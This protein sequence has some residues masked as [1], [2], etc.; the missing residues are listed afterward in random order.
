MNSFFSVIGIFCIMCVSHYLPN[1]SNYL[2]SV[3]I[4]NPT[5]L[6]E[7]LPTQL[8]LFVTYLKMLKCPGLVYLFDWKQW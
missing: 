5:C 6:Y 4:R 2:R 3:H 7:L 8:H 1:Y